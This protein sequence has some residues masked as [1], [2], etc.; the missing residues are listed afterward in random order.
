[1]A[2]HLQHTKIL[3]SRAVHTT[4]ELQAQNVELKQE[5]LSISSEFEM[6]KENC[7]GMLSECEKKHARDAGDMVTLQSELKAMERTIGELRSQIAAQEQSQ[8][9]GNEV[10]ALKSQ[11]VKA[12]DEKAVLV[13]KVNDVTSSAVAAKRARDKM[14]A[15]TELELKSSNDALA[16]LTKQHSDV[17]AANVTASKEVEA[18]KSQL[19]EANDRKAVLT[20]KINDIT[21]SAVAAKSTRDKMILETELE[22]KTSNAALAKMTKQ[23][24]DVTAANLTASKELEALKGQIEKA[25]DEKAMLTK[26]INDVTSS[27]VAAKTARDKMILET[28]IELK[29]CQEALSVVTKQLDSL[30]GTSGKRIESLQSQVTKGNEEKAALSDK[31]AE[32][33]STVAT[34]NINIKVSTL[35]PSTI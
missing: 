31:I 20:K 17:V 23:H 2:A 34:L 9:K 26:K 25:K 16:T 32:L 35:F 11:L 22:L 8:D 6:Y 15:E 19:G 4:A 30:Q 7:S 33:E 18:L 1:M 21:S 13:K 12:N 28:E 27:A 24:S 3:A 10:D 29:G 5:L 14:I